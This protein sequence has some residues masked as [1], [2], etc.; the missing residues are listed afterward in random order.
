MV[1]V[2]LHR[3]FEIVCTGGT[4]GG[5]GYNWFDGYEWS[6][7]P[8]SLP[9]F[10][11]SVTTYRPRT[12]IC[13]SHTADRATFNKNVENALFAT[14]LATNATGWSLDKAEALARSVG[15]NMTQFKGL[16]NGVGFAGLVID[17]AQLYM[18]IKDKNL[19]DWTES[20]YLN[21]AQVVLGGAAIVA[22]GW[23]A[24]SLGAVSIGIAVYSQTIDGQPTCQ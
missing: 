3:S 24:V 23:I 18:G 22:G 15:G 4:G 8:I 17:G 12:A 6:Y 21:L 11:T 7:T 10:D 14:G 2:T 1:T 20:D 5:G 16:I 19:G 9:P 13:H